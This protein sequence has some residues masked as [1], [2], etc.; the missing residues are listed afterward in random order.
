MV[1]SEKATKAQQLTCHFY[2][3]GGNIVGGVGGVLCEHMDDP[4]LMSLLSRI[5]A[6]IQYNT[7][8]EGHPLV[9]VIHL[10]NHILGSLVGEI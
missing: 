4:F 2:Y 3:G 7:A 10:H 8:K 1:S 9:L 6:G 5:V